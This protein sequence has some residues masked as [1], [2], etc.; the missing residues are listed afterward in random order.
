MRAE[1]FEA[2]VRRTLHAGRRWHPAEVAF[3]LVAFAAFLVVRGVEWSETVAV[4]VVGGVLVMIRPGTPPA[5][6]R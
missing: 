4:T 3:W 5:G 2:K 1:S 6:G